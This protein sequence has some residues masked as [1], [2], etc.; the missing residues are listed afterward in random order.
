[1]DQD[2]SEDKDTENGDSRHDLPL[3]CEIAIREETEKEVEEELITIEVISEVPNI[4]L[5]YINVQ[6]SKIEEDINAMNKKGVNAELDASVPLIPTSSFDDIN[7]KESELENNEEAKSDKIMHNS[8]EPMS[9]AEKSKSQESALYIEAETINV[10]SYPRANEPP[11]E[12]YP[13]ALTKSKNNILY[14]IAESLAIPRIFQNQRLED[15]HA[16]II[17]NSHDNPVF[18]TTKVEKEASAFNMY[19]KLDNSSNII[20]DNVNQ[21]LSS[22]NNLNASSVCATSSSNYVTAS[23]ANLSDLD[24]NKKDMVSTELSNTST[25]VKAGTLFCPWSSQITDNSRSMP[26]IKSNSCNNAPILPHNEVRNI[27]A[28]KLENPPS[29]EANE[30]CQLTSKSSVYQIIESIDPLDHQ[31]LDVKELLDETRNHNVN[32]SKSRS[33]FFL[34]RSPTVDTVD[35]FIDCENDEEQKCQPFS[36]S[37]GRLKADL[38]I[39]YLKLKVLSQSLFSHRNWRQLCRKVHLESTL[40]R[41]TGRPL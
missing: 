18:T 16:H 20:E 9:A 7:R 41:L 40:R 31:I 6:Q 13:Y 37:L 10:P 26:N 25:P 24:E 1:M 32:V 4:E 28:D 29:M 14:V 12:F 17:H 11:L 19:D 39:L 5:A 38:F 30:K 27:L 3:P 8:V 34:P 2:D 23:S 33:S 35:T 21:N 22:S 15:S 36:K